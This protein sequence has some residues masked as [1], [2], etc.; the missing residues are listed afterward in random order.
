MPDTTQFSERRWTVELKSPA[1][2]DV[3]AVLFAWSRTQIR[4][5]R[6]VLPG[7][8]GQSTQPLELERQGRVFEG[9]IPGG[10]I[11]AGRVE[12]RV[13]FR[14]NVPRVALLLW[15][16]EKEAPRSFPNLLPAGLD[17]PAE[18]SGADHF[19]ERERTRLEVPGRSITLAQLQDQKTQVAALEGQLF[20]VRRKALLS[21][22]R[23][24]LFFL[25]LD[26]RSDLANASGTWKDQ[27]LTVTAE[28]FRRIEVRA[29]RGVAGQV[30]KFG[31]E[32]DPEREKWLVA[33]LTAVSKLFGELVEKHL[34]S[35]KG[36]PPIFD[37]AFEQF[38]ACSAGAYHHDPAIHRQIQKC[39]IPDSAEF[40]KF[41]E[42]GLACLD[43][44]TQPDL[45][46]QLLP[47]LV[48]S[49]H[50][51]L[52]Q[53][54]KIPDPGQA[55][56]LG[57]NYFDHQQGRYLHCDWREEL[58]AQ[59]S[60][61]LSGKQPDDAERFLRHRFSSILAQAFGDT[62]TDE[63]NVTT[64]PLDVSYKAQ[65]RRRFADVAPEANT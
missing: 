49:S 53:Q 44:G 2:I 62:L 43:K 41:A 22:A 17:W 23:V 34:Q 35:Q 55:R 16:G 24:R 57:V 37:W 65:V 63:P 18:P 56:V 30:P 64:E 3:L 10:S 54:S 19:V 5:V 21:E 6:L 28:L 59:Y 27:M 46:R 4:A 50:L 26:E 38:T 51:F 31:P 32:T 7:G 25:E 29:R 1:K 9:K 15:V 45:W 13:E 11:P 42:L 20:D 52:E 8:E 61:A 39:G 14:G 47:V 40:F 60:S 48:R 12:L 33:S 58:Q 36:D